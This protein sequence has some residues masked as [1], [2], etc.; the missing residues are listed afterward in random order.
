MESISLIKTQQINPVQTRLEQKAASIETKKPA[1][2]DRVTISDD[3]QSPQQIL[4]KKVLAALNKEIAALGGTEIEKLDPADYTP[5]KVSDR[6]LRFIETAILLHAGEDPDE[7]Q[8]MLQ[9]A[10]DG[11]DRGFSEAREILSGLGVLEGDVASN[12]DKTYDLIM[13]GL[14]DLGLEIDSKKIKEYN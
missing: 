3:Y 8:A 5:E 14:E 12:A 11:V 13:Q 4:N 9:L 2:S 7:R 6:I 1:E 10:R